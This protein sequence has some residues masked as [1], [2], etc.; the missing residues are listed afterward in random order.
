MLLNM[1]DLKI[2]LKLNIRK[3][4]TLLRIFEI[5][6]LLRLLK[7]GTKK[8]IFAEKTRNCQNFK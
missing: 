3:I 5:F 4:I 7:N 2:N 1:I 6:L 8:H